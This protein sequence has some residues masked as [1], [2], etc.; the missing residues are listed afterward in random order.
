MD[1]DRLGVDLLSLSGHKIGGPKGVGVLY[2]RRGTPIEPLIAGGGQERQRRSGTENVPGIVGMGVALELAEAERE[3]TAAHSRR[4][5]DMIIEGVVERVPGARLNGHLSRRLPNNVNF[6][7]PGVE[8]EP[9]V[10]GLDLAGICVSSGS[11]C[12]SASIEPSHVLVALGLDAEQAVGSVRL[13]LGRDN[14]EAEARRVI[15]ALAEVVGRLR[16]MPSLGGGE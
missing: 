8:G 12:S 1:V 3:E 4:L 11:A 16:A 13:T 14:T 7:F 9:V 10:I 2:V 15:E 6:S 5:R